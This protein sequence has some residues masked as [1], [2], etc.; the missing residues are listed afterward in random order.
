LRALQRK[1]ENLVEFELVWKAVAKVRIA[2][3]RKSSSA[4][5]AEVSP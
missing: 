3:A 5:Q 4:P 1:Y 2:L